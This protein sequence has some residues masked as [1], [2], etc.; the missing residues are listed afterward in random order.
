MDSWALTD[1]GN[2]S[3]LAHAHSHAE[4]MKKAGRKYRQI[5]GVEFYFVPSLTEW[6]NQ[7]EAHRESV[8]DKKSRVN[9]DDDQGGH[10]IEDEDASKKGRIGKPAYKK[11]YHLVVLAKNS[12][13]LANL[14]TLVKKSYKHGFYRFPRIDY[15]MLKEHGEGLIVSTA[16][17]SGDAII[18]TSAGDIDMKSL[19]ERFNAGEEFNILSYDE[20]ELRPIFKPMKWGDVTRKN[21]KV[22][23]LTLKDGKTVKLTHDH[24]VFTD[25]GWLKVEE[26]KD[27]KDIKILNIY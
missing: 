4:K 6:R 23:K 12:V 19:V 25:I 14:F 8:K 11:Y 15:A 1:H 3:G 7:Y 26:L 27:Y 21:T 18:Q 2:G 9:K 10:I 13:G 16:C 20:N 24:F 17:V 22:Y 5:N